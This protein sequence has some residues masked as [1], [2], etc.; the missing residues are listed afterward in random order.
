M[1]KWEEL[2]EGALAATDLRKCPHCVSSRLLGLPKTNPFSEQRK[3]RMSIG[4]HFEAMEAT[5]LK[6]VAPDAYRGRVM[7]IHDYAIPVRLWPD[8]VIPVDGKAAKIIEV[9]YRTTA[10]LTIPIDWSYQAGVYQLRFGGI[11]AQF[12]VYSLDSHNLLEQESPPEDIG[13]RLAEFAEMMADVL[14]GSLSIDD[15]PHDPKTCQDSEWAC[16]ECYGARHSETDLIDYERERLMEFLELDRQAEALAQVKRD[17]DRAEAAV[18]EIVL[19]HEGSLTFQ[20]NEWSCYERVQRSG[21]PDKEATPPEVLEQ[22][23]WKSNT[24]RPLKYREM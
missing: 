14:N 22:I 12:S 5:R 2:H 20:G 7:V 4:K 3:Q 16:A 17:R 10:P 6:E 8:F 21:Y 23:I 18:K 15:L 1:S 9:K 24:V 13:D 19:A 11:P